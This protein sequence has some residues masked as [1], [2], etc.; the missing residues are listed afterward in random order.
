MILQLEEGV[1]DADVYP[2]VPRSDSV[3]LLDLDATL[4]DVVHNV[5]VSH[6]GDQMSEEP[7]DKAWIRNLVPLA[8]I[9]T[10]FLELVHNHGLVIWVIIDPGVD[11]M[12]L[13]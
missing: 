5:F 9:D 13:F 7:D 2:S 11:L 3:G 10:I 8:H 1:L 12:R 6:L 4:G